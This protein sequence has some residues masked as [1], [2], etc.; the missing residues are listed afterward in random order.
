M[1]GVG[2]TSAR[3]HTEAHLTRVAFVFEGNYELALL[4]VGQVAVLVEVFALK[5]KEFRRLARF[6]IYSTVQS[7][8]KPNV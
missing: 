3:V 8:A 1:I 2:L 4:R 6:C 7:D 5:I